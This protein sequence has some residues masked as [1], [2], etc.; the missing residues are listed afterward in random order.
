MPPSRYQQLK[1]LAD[2]FTA[3]F[4]R[5]DLDACMS[6]FH[7]HAVYEELHGRRNE[8]LAAIRK[9]FEGLFSKKF[10]TM[11][12]DEDDTFIDETS[13]KVMA[14][15]RLHLTMDGKPVALAGLDLLYFDGDKLVRK[16]TYCKAKQPLYLEQ[17]Q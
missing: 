4:N 10:G 3:T 8:G 1:T 12:F 11:R 7:E 6:Y 2:S 9:A 14:S 16:L 15:W 17:A 5:H 13:G